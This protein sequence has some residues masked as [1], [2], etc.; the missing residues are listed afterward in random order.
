MVAT[1]VRTTRLSEAT[2]ARLWDVRRLA[3]TDPDPDGFRRSWIMLFPE[4]DFS[5]PKYGE[6][7]F[8]AR[9]LADIKRRFDSRVRHIDIALDANHDQDKATGWLERL[10]LRGPTTAPDGEALPAGLWGLVRWTPLGVQYLKDQIY[11]YFSPEFGP[12]EDPESGKEYDDVLMGGGLTNRPFLKNMPAV[13][14]AERGATISRRPWGDVDKDCLPD[15]AFLDPKGRRLPVYEGTGPKDAR[16]RYTR[17]GALN[18]NGVKAALAAVHGARSGAAMTGLPAGTEAKLRGWLARY[19]DSGKAASEAGSRTA[20]RARRTSGDG[21]MG[22]RD[23][24]GRFLATDEDATELD[25]GD[26]YAEDDGVDAGEEFADGAD[27][28]SEYMDDAEDAADGGAD[29]A[30]EGDGFDAEADTHGAMTVKAHSHGKYG[31]HSHSDDGDHSEAPMK[32]SAKG[33]SMREPRDHDDHDERPLTL[34]ERAQFKQMRE[35]LETVRYQL[36]ETE[37]G[38]TLDGWAKQ[39]FQFREGTKAGKPVAKSGRIALSKAFTEAYRAFMLKEGV[40]LSEGQRRQVNGLIE[41]A[42]STAVV[43]LSER[44]AAT[45]DQ[46]ERRTERR[47]GTRAPTVEQADRLT[48][49]AERIAREEGKVLAELDG[50]ATLA[51]YERATKDI[52]YR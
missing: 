10:D 8:T 17:R 28:E 6:L 25:E 51:L 30:E 44:A 35:Q 9:R 19:S 36:Y 11:R 22:K 18:L 24:R 37:V 45:F 26:E 27:D 31:R 41:S 13:Q 43:D 1:P 38:K 29:D 5:H 42:L 7:H 16:G 49:A 39:S 4:G 33:K 21:G 15:S 50:P 32:M 3:L 23:D 47:G 14:L 2:L 20:R 40:R 52:E 46:E 12:W 34:T 48:A